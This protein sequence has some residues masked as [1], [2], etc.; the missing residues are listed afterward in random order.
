MGKLITRGIC[1]SGAQLQAR[2]EKGK[3]SEKEKRYV[4]DGVC[5]LKNAR[6]DRKSVV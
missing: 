6:E 2:I 5:G 3:A 1:R 4:I